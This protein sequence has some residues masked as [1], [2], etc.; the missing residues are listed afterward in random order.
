MRNK[1]NVKTGS[2]CW[3]FGSGNY[4]AGRTKDDNSKTI[5]SANNSMQIIKH[6]EIKKPTPGLAKQG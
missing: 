6:Q 1:D 3:V 5:S 2:G 4:N